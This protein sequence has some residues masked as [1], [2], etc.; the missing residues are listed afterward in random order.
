MILSCQRRIGQAE[1]DFLDLL[2][3]AGARYT[4]VGPKIYRIVLA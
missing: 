4:V 3:A 1:R 2:E